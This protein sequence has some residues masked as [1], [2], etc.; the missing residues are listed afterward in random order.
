MTTATVDDLWLEGAAFSLGR[1][2]AGPSDSPETA[3]AR[4]D[5]MRLTQPVNTNDGEATLRF[6]MVRPPTGGARPWIHWR[7]IGRV[8]AL[9]AVVA[10]GRGEAQNN[11][12][13]G[14]TGQTNFTLGLILFGN[15]QNPLLTDSNLFWDNTNK[16]LG[17]GT[18]APTMKLDVSG[19]ARVSGDTAPVFRLNSAN[20]TLV[21]AVPLGRIEWYTNDPSVNGTGAGAAIQANTEHTITGSQGATDLV[22]S[23]RS[24]PNAAAEVMRI[25]G[26]GNVGIGT[27]TPANKLHVAG[28]IT[29]DGNINAKYQDVAEWVPSSGM[30]PP[31]TV[32]VIDGN[33]SNAILPSSAAYDTRIAGVV[34]DTPGLLLGEAGEN[35]AKVATTGRVKV[36]ATAANGAIRMGDL[37]V[38]SDL[39]G[40]AMKS[41]PARLAGLEMHRPGTLVGKALEPLSEG[42]GEILVLLS[43]Q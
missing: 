30:V 9:A 20:T 43:L 19:D 41:V 23:T 13:Q 11:V 29:V 18:T 12:S 22:F 33:R 40:L 1:A 25:T 37:L 27:A 14:F 4:E 5:N 42:E 32:V 15:G 17:I 31:G 6:P 10:V 28:S 2:F 3:N 39:P 8:A 34:T 16:R 38:T 35:K 26:A 36:R 21:G 24:D 7:S